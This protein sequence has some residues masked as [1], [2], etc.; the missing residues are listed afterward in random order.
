MTSLRSCPLCLLMIGLLSLFCAGDLEPAQ[1]PM[2]TAYPD[3]GIAFS[4]VPE[5]KEALY[6]YRDWRSATAEKMIAIIKENIEKDKNK[7]PRMTKTH[8]AIEMLGELRAA[9]ATEYP[10][11]IIDFQVRDSEVLRDERKHPATYSLIQ[12]GKKASL[13]CLDWVATEDNPMRRMLMTR[14]ILHVETA[15]LGR[16]ILEGKLRNASGDAMKKRWR[17]VIMDF[18][19][20]AEWGPLERPSPADLF[21][22]KLKKFGRNQRDGVDVRTA[23]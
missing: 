19:E 11:S 4:K 13:Y 6:G 18:K 12:I 20:G 14:V 1:A 23:V 15:P 21:K 5:A 17:A 22:K 16:D 7:F 2:K 8:L 10:V 9:E 3:P